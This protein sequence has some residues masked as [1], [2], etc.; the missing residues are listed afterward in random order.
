MTETLR[1]KQSRFAKQLPRL[2]DYAESL[3]YEV[4]LGECYRT[5]EQAEINAIGSA[6][7]ESV[8]NMVQ[9]QFPLLAAKLRNNTGNGIRNSLH[10]VR[11]AID[12]QLFDAAGTWVQATYPY[13]LIGEYWESLAPDHRWGGR[14]GDTPHFS[15]EH[16]GRK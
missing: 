4:T 14:F 13:M 6:G 15:I 8:A 3:G 7:R 1:Q 9:G 11:L 16:E 2:L 12:L 10:C 5:D